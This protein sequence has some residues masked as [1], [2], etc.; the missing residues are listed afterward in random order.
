MRLIIAGCRNIEWS[1]LNTLIDE[2]IKYITETTNDLNNIEIV[3]GGAYGADSM[4]EAFANRFNLPL[5]KFPAD[6][7]KYGKRAGMIRNHQ[8]G[9]Y[10]THL[11]A[12]WDGKSRG[13]NDMINYMKSLNKNVKIIYIKY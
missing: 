3:S 9:D 13:T 11:I 5:K 7:D 4:G 10:A 2:S 8:M 1:Y 6:W 12:F